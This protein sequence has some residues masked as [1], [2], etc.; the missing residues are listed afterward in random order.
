MPYRA[1]A[2]VQRAQAATKT[3][4]PS[5]Y[6]D[7]QTYVRPI[8]TGFALIRHC[9]MTTWCKPFQK[10]KFFKNMPPVCG[11]STRRNMGKRNETLA[12]P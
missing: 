10:P 5:G 4:A 6:I 7:S 12:Y 9:R 3:V 2:P 1:L 11:E 8:G